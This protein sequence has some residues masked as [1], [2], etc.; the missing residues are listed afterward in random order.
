MNTRTGSWRVIWMDENGKDY[1][2]GYK[3]ITGIV[4]AIWLLKSLHQ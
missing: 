3:K 1:Y 2:T 4:R